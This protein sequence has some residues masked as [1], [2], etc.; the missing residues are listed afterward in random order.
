MEGPFLPIQVTP[1]ASL[2][3]G[4][5]ETVST[6]PNRTQDAAICLSIRQ[7]DA[8]AGM[9]DFVTAEIGQSINVVVRRGRQLDLRE[10]STIQLK[11]SY[12][13]DERGG[14]YYANASDY[15]LIQ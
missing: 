3:I 9:P 7:A 12:E 15:Q 4:T 5:I 2:A 10:G 13:G 6:I 11:I 1:N 8:I 14:G